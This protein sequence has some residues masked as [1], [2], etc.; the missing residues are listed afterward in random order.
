MTAVD[1]KVDEKVARPGVAGDFK[2]LWSAA[3]ISRVGDALR[4]AA[5]PL[6]AVALTDSPVLVSLV[7]AAGFLPWLLF[8]LVGGAVADRVDQRRAM[9]AVDVVRGL[10]MAAF[11]AA[12]A[13]GAATIGLL[14][15]VAFALT[16]LQT[17][18][19]NAATALLP[20]VVDET[21]LGTANAR[22]MTGQQ[23]AGSFV[24][25]PLVPVLLGIGLAVPYAADAG[26][27]LLAAV[28]VAG[29]RADPPPRPA[30]AAGRTLRREIADGIRALWRDRLLRRLCAA[31]TL[32]NVGVG[33]LI[34]MLPLLVKGWLDAGNAGYA[35]AIAAYGV[36]GVAGGLAAGRI[37]GRLGPAR[38]LLLGGALQTG[39]LI[40]LGTARFLPATIA[41]MAAFGFVG[42][43]WNVT[44]V[45]LMQRRSPAGMLGRTS[46]AFRT[47]GVAGAP[48]GAL[49]GGAVA[50][51]WGLNT[52]ML[53]A[54]ALFV[55]A[56]A[57]LSP[58]LK[59]T[60]ETK[61]TGGGEAAETGAGAAA[62]GETAV[63]TGGEAAVGRGE[64][65]DGGQTSH[66]GA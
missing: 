58:A 26:T 60:K 55:L 21:A 64:A 31:T 48:F 14:I 50:A 56:V 61:E 42:M 46:A 65:A 51:A 49:A 63:E 45:T 44:Q 12:V 16:A 47:L 36:G 5:L 62:G 33:A 1:A 11:A 40:V 28:L 6:L 35:A 25:A 39:C 10:L 15:A 23:I 9:W 41:A 3:V 22:L 4:S 32:C 29:V 19:D 17:L 52:P 43:L 2:R 59:E 53:L 37:T 30:R 27:Y 8:G 13:C 24:G 20:A 7:T 34:A 66:T 54:A 57:A 38:S 18:F